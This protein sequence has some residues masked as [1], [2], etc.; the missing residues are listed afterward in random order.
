MR[1]FI[2]EKVII[3]IVYVRGLELTGLGAVTEGAGGEGGGTAINNK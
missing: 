3:S 1:P 2:S